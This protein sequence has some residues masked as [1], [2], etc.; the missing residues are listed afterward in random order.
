[1]PYLKEGGS[2]TLSKQY[3][4]ARGFFIRLSGRFAGQ[5]GSARHKLWCRSLHVFKFDS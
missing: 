4:S 5:Y 3:S 2:H 1:M